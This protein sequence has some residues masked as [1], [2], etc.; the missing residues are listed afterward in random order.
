MKSTLITWLLIA[1]GAATSLAQARLTV[2]VTGFKTNQ[3]LCKIWLFR[4]AKGFPTND[5]EAFRCVE[6]PIKALTSQ[7]QFDQL[8]LGNYAVSA[9][10]DQNNNHQLD[11]WT[12]NSIVEI[13]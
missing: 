4:S 6:V 9:V 13:F 10:H 8:P 2:H 12:C 3:G 11:S 5:K 1:L 7:F